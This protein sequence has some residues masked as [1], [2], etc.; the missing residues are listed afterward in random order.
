MATPRIGLDLKHEG[1]RFQLSGRDMIELAVAAEEAGIESAWTNE[2]IGFDAFAALSAMAQH[3]SRIR[4]GTA[5][6]NV[7]NRSAMQLAMGVATLDELSGG[8]AILGLSIGH[9]PWNDLGHGI[10]LE[11]PLARLREYVTFIRKTLGGQPFRH[12][13]A[14]FRG[15]DTQLAFD[16]VRPGVPIFIAGERS[17]ILQLAGEVADGLLITVESPEYIADFAAERF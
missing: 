5:I 6:V 9:H 4:L 7:Y 17:R 16:P 1:R 8:R 13:G 12:D 14:L 10:P 2:D 3:T 11:A 15:V